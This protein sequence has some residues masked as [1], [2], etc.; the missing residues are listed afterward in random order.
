MFFFLFSRVC[1]RCLTRKAV[2]SSGVL[3][4]SFV[5]F[6]FF[7]QEIL[8]VLCLPDGLGLSIRVV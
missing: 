1:D 8:L 4:M 5:C 3:G 6:P 2:F 7:F